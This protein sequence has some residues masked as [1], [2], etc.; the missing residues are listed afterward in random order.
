MKL[1]ISHSLGL[2]FTNTGRIER[3]RRAWRAWV[4]LRATIHA[5]T[6]LLCA[7]ALLGLTLWMT[8]HFN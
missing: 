8:G 7:G 2:R 4:I 5:S 1:Q 6:C 3:E